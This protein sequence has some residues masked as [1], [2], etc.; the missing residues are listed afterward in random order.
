MEVPKNK[1]RRLTDVHDTQ[2]TVNTS[3]E[4]GSSQI[5]ITRVPVEFSRAG[6]EYAEGHGYSDQFKRSTESQKVYQ[7]TTAKDYSVVQNGDILGNVTNTYNYEMKTTLEARPSEHEEKHQ[8]LKESLR[9]SGIGARLDNISPAMP[10][11]CSWLIEHKHF[12]K[13]IKERGEQNKPFFWIVGKPGCGKST[14]MKSAHSYITEYY[15]KQPAPWT[16]H[17]YF[18]NARAKGE[19]EKSALGLF[20]S[21]VHDMLETLPQL[22]LH[23]WQ[24][25]KRKVIGDDIDPWTTQELQNFL[26]ETIHLLQQPL[27]IFIDALDE[28]KVEDARRIIDFFKDY[29]ERARANGVQLHV[30]FSSRHYPQVNIPDSLNITVENEPA[31]DGDIRLYIDRKLDGSSEPHIIRLAN[32]IHARSAQV[33]LWVVLVV[34]ILNDAQA[35]GSSAA[36]LDLC[37]EQLPD[38]LEGLFTRILQPNG[39]DLDET[40][41]MFQWMLFASTRLT[42]QQLLLAVYWSRR[43]KFRPSI[44]EELYRGYTHELVSI[45]FAQRRLIQLSKGLLEV[46]KGTEP[47]VQFIHETV[48]VFLS[49]PNGLQRLQANLSINMVGES[50]VCLMETCSRYLDDLRPWRSPEHVI[51]ALPEDVKTFAGEFQ[52]YCVNNVYQHAEQAQIHGSCLE[53]FLV[54]RNEDGFWTDSAFRAHFNLLQRY[55]VRRFPLAERIPLLYALAHMNLPALAAFVIKQGADVNVEGGRY[56]T[57]LQAATV[58]GDEA[59]VVLLLQHGAHVNKLGGFHN[60]SLLAALHGTHLSIAQRLLEHNARCEK[61]AIA[62]SALSAIARGKVDTLK[63]M[64]ETNLIVLSEPIRDMTLL[65]HAVRKKRPEIVRMILQLGGNAAEI[66]LMD[67]ALQ[68]GNT[69]SIAAIRDACPGLLPDLTDTNELSSISDTALLTI[70]NH[71]AR[72]ESMTDFPLHRFIEYLVRHRSGTVLRDLINRIPNDRLY[73]LKLGPLLTD[74]RHLTDP[75]M[76]T[77]LLKLV[78]HSMCGLTAGQASYTALQAGTARGLMQTR[79]CVRGGLLVSKCKFQ[80]HAARDI[81]SA[82]L[83]HWIVP[84]KS[85]DSLDMVLST[86]ITDDLVVAIEDN[87][88]DKWLQDQLRYYFRRHPHACFATVDKICNDMKHST[89]LV[90]FILECST[91][92]KFLI[93]KLCQTLSFGLYNPAQACVI[94]FMVTHGMT[95]SSLDSHKED[96][97]VTAASIEQPVVLREFCREFVVVPD[98]YG[99]DDLDYELWERIHGTL[100]EEWREAFEEAVELAVRHNRWSN[101]E[102]LA[103]CWNSKASG[104][105]P[106]NTSTIL[107][108]AWN[109]WRYSRQSLPPRSHQSWARFHAFYNHYRQSD[110][111][112]K[113]G[114]I[115]SPDHAAIVWKLFLHLIRFPNDRQWTELKMNTPRR[116][117]AQGI[118]DTIREAAGITNCIHC[119]DHRPH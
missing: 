96:V 26:L 75:E 50:H 62:N 34:S 8:K 42:L 48:R 61:Q 74:V 92:P 23:F 44:Y 118:P 60:H 69:G 93:I 119:R 63:F 107:A 40:V 71:T 53:K 19:L 46:T 68:T 84:A 100:D 1:R 86:G 110:T 47:G 79:S 108:A 29:L 81:Y 15:G 25:F 59:T 67:Q 114:T 32:S 101:V 91:E 9:F 36:D 16:I 17:N 30:C 45:D 5:D 98:C 72:L 28:G 112:K 51:I 115:R 22:D 66:G 57:A 21:L 116:D 58:N 113:H 117:P 65:W 2:D 64:V 104:P 4:G 99:K 87:M 33:F 31:H 97:L 20:R 37:L 55:A 18:F 82:V 109:F 103:H 106:W 95:L 90:S 10:Q 12:Q 11:T 38:D 80:V 78:E 39:S 41:N 76:A 111:L 6:L 13:W 70:F 88:S 3:L 77:S 105:A 89:T 52:S 94:G 49:S 7:K 73:D 27:C 85:A 35:Q 14:L 43:P 56:G 54:A 102:A 83:N 24:Q